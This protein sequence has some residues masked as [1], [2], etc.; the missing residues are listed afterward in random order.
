M[1]SPQ[2]DDEESDTPLSFAQTLLAKCAPKQKYLSPVF[3]PPTSVYIESL[4]SRA[5]YVWT[6]RRASA[7]PVHVE[8]QMFLMIN[9]HFWD[10]GT[11][12]QCINSKSKK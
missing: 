6:D 5:G 2:T 12:Q 9:H 3:I 7:L 4:F 10:A 11:V 1:V 8:E